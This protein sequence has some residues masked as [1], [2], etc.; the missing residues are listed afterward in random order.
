MT[1]FLTVIC[2]LFGVVVLF[3]LSRAVNDWWQGRWDLVDRLEKR[4]YGNGGRYDTYTVEDL[5]WK[6]ERL[7][8]SV[9]HIT[10]LQGQDGRAI[11][12]LQREVFPPTGSDGT[13]TEG[14]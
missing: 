12:D 13:P 2:T 5:Y 6:V 14:E 9:E 1:I 3:G 10:A 11:R 7:K 8:S 4:M